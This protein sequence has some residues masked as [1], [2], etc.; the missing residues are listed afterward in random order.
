M[1]GRPRP[2]PDRGEVLVKVSAAGICR[3][4]LAIFEG[5]YAVPLPLVLGHEL[6]GCVVET[7]PGVEEGYLGRRVVCEINWTC[8]SRRIPDPCPLCARG[9]PHHCLRRTV[10]G[11]QGWDGAFSQLLRAPAVNL[12][13]LPE[14]ISLHEG[15][16]IEPL[17]AAIQTFALSELNPGDRVAVL[18][19]GRLGVLLCKVA[20]LQGARVIAISRSGGKLARARAFGAWQTLNAASEDLVAR[21]AELTEGQGADMVIEAT[22]SPEG[23]NLAVDLVRPRGIIALKSTPGTPAAANL[24]QMVVKELRIQGSRCGPFDQAISLLKAGQIDVRPL[25]SRAYPLEELEAALREA[26]EGEGKVLV[27]CSP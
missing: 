10:M 16:F 12:H 26:S 21:M 20:S 8:L 7:G 11:I 5:D 25:I 14:G 2:K 3:T 1:E 17:A 23:L 19:V 27:E 18:G 9:E 24:T 13:L 4:D 22:G 6:C 15:V